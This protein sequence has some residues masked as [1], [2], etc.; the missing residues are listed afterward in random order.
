M[1]VTLRPYRPE[2]FD[3]SARI[4]QISGSENLD[5]WRMRF[6]NSGIW[7]DHYLHLAISVDNFLVGDLQIR[8]CPLSM[9]PGAMELGID[10][11]L[12]KQGLGIGTEVLRISSKRMFNDGAHRLS[13]STHIKNV[14]MIRAFEKAGWVHE[15]TLRGLFNISGELHDYESYAVIR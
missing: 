14:A 13:G 1:A 6:A 11:A 10:I 8:H 2:E 15:G 12:E 4:R 5:N 9:P 7:D 3:E